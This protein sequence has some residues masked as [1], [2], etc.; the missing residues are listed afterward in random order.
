M[1]QLEVIIVEGRNLKQKD[2]FSENDAYVKVYLDDKS[3]KQK[4][5]TIQNS[6]NPKWNQSFVFNHLTG[7]DTLYID[8]YDK[9]SVK[10]EKIGSIHIDLH[11]LYN[12]GR[13]DNW[14]HIPAKNGS[15]SCGEIHLILHYERLQL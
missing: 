5:K 15:T 10:D 2:T 12:K 14:F 7:Q 8:I 11:D 9:D 13:I 1:G 3:Q 4:S 6:N